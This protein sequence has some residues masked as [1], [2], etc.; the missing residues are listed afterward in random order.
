[1]ADQRISQ[2][3][4]LAQGDVA[5]NDVLAIV[6]VGAS[7][8]KKVEA[9]DLFQAGANLADSASID[10]IKLNQSSTTKLGTTALA[11]DAVTA[12]KLADDSSIAYD[13]VAPSTNNFEG[14]GYVNST[15]KNLQVWDG[16]AFQQVVAP[17]TGI[18]DL[19]VTTGK[20]ANNAVTT[21]KVDAAGLAAA[22][23]A[24]DSVTT[25]KIQDLAVTTGKL[26]ALSV[27]TAKIAA[28]AVTADEL[29]SNAVVTAS[30]VD[31]NVT[32]AKLAAGAVT[33]AK[34]AAA[35]VTVAKVAD[36]SLTYAKLNL[37]DA[38]VPG[39]KLV[40]N[41]VTST[42]LAVDAVTTGAITALNVTTAKLADGAV[43]AAKLGALAVT[44]AKIAADAVTAAEL[45]ND[46]V[47]TA[48]IVNAAVTEAKLAA[49][50]VTEAKIATS[51]VTVGKIADT[52]IT[53]AKLNLADG[54]VPGA[55]LVSNS[56]T[57]TQLAVNAVTTGALTD[58]NVTTGKLADSAVTNAKLATG[59]I[60][61]AKIDA[62]GLGEAAIAT[63]A[64]TTSK[65]LD[66]AI[67]AAKLAADS[68]TI[69]QAGTPVGS[70]AYEGQLWF[71]TNTS[72]KY[73]WNGSAWIRQA[74]LNSINFSDTTPLNFA[75]V[76]PDNHTAN[77][78]TTLDTQDANA[79][80]AG[81]TSGADAAPTFR[82]LTP[83]DLP[84]ATASTKGIVQP[85]TGLAVN[86]GVLN[87]SNSVAPGTYTRLVVDA[88]G[89][90][91]QGQLLEASDIPN[92][93]AAKITTGEL[94][95]ARIADAAIT[96]DKLANY[97]TASIGT[98]F[99]EATFTGQL[100][101]N[102]LDRSF[103]MWDG[104][105][106]VPIGISAGQIVLA[107]TFDASSPSGVGKVQSLT[108]EG[109]AAG[110]VVNSALPVPTLNNSKHYFVVSEGGT[111]TSGN[112]P[113]G[114]LA[115]PDLLLSVYSTTLPQW[116]EIDVSAG[117][118]AIAAANVSFV[119]A[120]DIAASNVQTAIE[121]VSTECRNATNIT[122]GT[123]AV[124][125]GGTNVASYTKGD[126]LA[127]SAATTLTKLPVGT[128]G[129]VL[130]AN[131]ATATGLEYGADFV[132]T[133]TTVTSST[134]ALT[135][136]NPTTTPALTVRAATTSVDGIVQLSDS[137]N[138]TSS[139][140]AATPTAVKSAYDLAA[141]ALPKAGGTVTGELLIGSA[142]TLVFE[143]STDDGNEI[144]LA[145]ADPTADRTITLP[146]VTGTVVTTGD[147]GTV[148]STM[149]AD[150]TVVNTD[151]SA[152]AAI[153]DT[154]LATIATAGKVS[155]SAT[156]ATSA[157]TASAIVARN[158]S[159]DF[160]A[161][162]ITASLSGNAS[163]V[164]TNAN[165]TG[166]V[167]S[168]GNATSIAAGVIVNA[169]INASA[170]IAGTKISPDFGSQTVATTGIFSHA[171]GSVSAPTITFTGDANTGIYSPGADT[172]AFVEGGVEAMRID[173][174]GNVGIGT[175][176]PS[177]RLEVIGE[178]RGVD[179]SFAL[180]ASNGSGT[181][182]T[183]IG[184]RREGAPTDQKTWE[185][186][187]GASGEFKLRTIN[188]T[189]TAGQDVFGVDRGTGVGV[190]SVQLHTNGS[191]RLRIDSSGR[192]GIG[193]S[194]PVT[195][196][197]VS[198]PS[199]SATIGNIRITPSTAGQARY[200]LYNGGSVAEWLFG[201]KTSTDHKFK[202]STSVAGS[203]T[204]VFTIDTNGNVG[205]GT[206]SPEYKLVANG[207][208]KGVAGTYA[209]L[210]SNGSGSGQTSIG[211]V[212]EGGTA[213]EKY[214]EIHNG[215]SGELKIRAINDTYTSAQ[216]AL[217]IGRGS[218]ATVSNF[219]IHTNGSERA[220]I[221]SV[222]RFGIGTSS[223]NYTLD[224]NSGAATPAQISTIVNWNFPGFILRRN[225]SNVSTA[226][227]LSMILQ[228]DTDSDTTLTNHLNIWGT[229]SAAPT[230]GSTTAG[231]SGVMNLGAPSGIALHVNGSER[232]RVDSSGRLLVGASSFR[233][234]GTI[235]SP[236]TNIQVEGS[237][238]GFYQVLTGVANR[239]DA[240]GPVIG[241][242]KSRGVANG[243]SAL[244][245]SGDSL[246]D[247]IFAGADGVDLSTIACSIGAYVDGAPG[248]DDMPGRLV[249]STTA[250]GASSPTERMRITQAGNVG[251]GASGPGTSLDVQ[252]PS[253]SATIGNIRVA[254]TST[255]QAR[256]HLFNGGAIAEWLFGQKTST[257]HDFK[258]S[259]SV[260]GS[261]ADYVA[262]KT[263]GII[264][265]AVPPTYADNAAA[266]SGGLVAGDI[267]RKSDGTLM[268]RY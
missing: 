86:A 145:V 30:I 56:V 128:N 11:D 144:T 243:S 166:D 98:E 267:Y 34:I 187:S 266:T 48:A 54:S 59:A 261:E 247:I 88:Q 39:A 129:Q 231:L 109:V 122:S 195:S 168:V 188:D 118:G 123:L 203:E 209:L 80:F 218:G 246:G 12:A 22:A 61:T 212:R 83:A 75:V 164:T 171:L 6:D 184:L 148:T 167:T 204:D 19:Q 215:A 1:M 114:A 197:E 248:T 198:L 95:T 189:Y 182:Q 172:L 179:G 154:K 210:A 132:G 70:G 181:G 222:G 119:P 28:D 51:A 60:T 264:N 3:T 205:I 220:R 50:A 260:A 63:S 87:H 92:L 130:R 18:G 180:L 258:L 235:F 232:G 44:T 255:G 121:E 207:T 35:A 10:L 156:T 141:L 245:Q 29:A 137:T 163:T 23:L 201:Q 26:A 185:F 69:V 64:V 74:A 57:S 37:A 229:Y 219:Q 146:N 138:T 106:Y 84:N 53:Y 227:M 178:I 13:S 125:R 73:V 31:A 102:S 239:N 65:V 105:V 153:V 25:I 103:Y 252:K 223:P 256:Y 230:T 190:A 89:H 15:S 158:A 157:N 228:G 14:R 238:D 216:D 124:A 139:V 211:L 55:K 58:L 81:P 226:K 111:I 52:Q 9:K 101:L 217:M 214:W 16:S 43:T 194:A 62:A 113:A 236:S 213:D 24:T 234:V 251:I 250:D 257:D 8:T 107:G 240:N 2:L 191:E 155:N 126:L 150:G 242:G 33:E 79:V 202:I 90:I 27:T 225:A 7:T 40:S 174:S 160:S 177:T 221:D 131:S 259:K 268:I 38:S 162:T 135:V 97:S 175:I 173:S 36:A 263:S 99:P 176:S 169:N 112:A 196:L 253:A 96:I 193:T 45:A 41:S 233:Q 149:I 170:A 127:A 200:Y 134:T 161:G 20:L 94:S 117:A 49:G 104:N 192:L 143:G 120:G 186:F 208:I 151:I 82:A 237:G 254:P 17:T 72:V 262:I 199:A 265:I 21:A 85:G 47:D 165:L 91:S 108:P 115:P 152:S 116:V 110:F 136:A 5:A 244:V 66:G 42:Q 100:H 147:S 206:T 78:T 32:E 77:I 76:Y 71:D 249:F 4:K 159:G 68:T 224:L 46:A 241:L 140:L 133:V 183:S 142:G 67:T 93:D